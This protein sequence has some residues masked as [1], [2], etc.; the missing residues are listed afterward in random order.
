MIPGF[1]VCGISGIILVVGSLGLVA[2]GHWPRTI[3]DWMGYGQTLGPLGLMMLGSVVLG[4]LLARYLPNIPF[5]NRLL[6]KPQVEEN[7]EIG[8]ESAPLATRPELA[9]LLGAIGVAATPLRPAGKVQFG[10]NFVD[11]VAEG[12]Y[13]QPGIAGAGH[14]DRG[15]PRRGQGS[16]KKLSAISSQQSAKERL[17]PE[18]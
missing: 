14:R 17:I 18:S 3:E 8:E 11:V 1:G 9:A 13:V 12:S 7:G 4:L 15:Q 10:D 2:Y 16:V 5:A 6:L